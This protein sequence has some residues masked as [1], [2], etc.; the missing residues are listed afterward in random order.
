MMLPIKVPSPSDNDKQAPNTADDIAAIFL[1]SFNLTTSLGPCTLGTAALATPR[2]PTSFAPLIK[3]ETTQPQ[4]AMQ[5]QFDYSAPARQFAGHVLAARL[6]KLRARHSELTETT[7]ANVHTR[8]E[9]LG[10][11]AKLGDDVERNIAAA[12]EGF[13][14]ARECRRWIDDDLEVDRFAMDKLAHEIQRYQRWLE[15]LAG[16]G[17]PNRPRLRQ[18]TEAGAK[19]EVE[20]QAA[21]VK[22]AEPKPA[23]FAPATA[24]EPRW[25]RGPQPPPPNGE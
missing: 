7:A 11:I 17:K 24:K 6:D 18:K 12:K 23:Q 14:W 25:K 9:L 2:S 15:E 19:A 4:P 20:A 10:V 5:M 21:Q 13:E 3:Y 16:G 8:R 1:S 22:T